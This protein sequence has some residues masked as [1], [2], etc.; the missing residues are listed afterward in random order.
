MHECVCVLS[1]LSMCTLQLQ[2]QF[3]LFEGHMRLADL[4]EEADEIELHMEK[5]QG[6]R[7]D[8]LNTFRQALEDGR[9]FTE[10]LIHGEQEDVG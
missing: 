2:Q 3:E 8:L 4:P 5:T 1:H 10:Q 9:A 7:K 6:D